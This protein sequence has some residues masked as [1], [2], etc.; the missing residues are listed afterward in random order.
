MVTNKKYYLKVSK[1]LLTFALTLLTLYILFKL[2]IFYTPFLIAFIIG[3]IIEPLIRKVMKITNLTRKTSAIVTVI[4]T[5][6]L[7]IFLLI[8][9]IIGV[10]TEAE[11]IL[12]GL[13]DDIRYIN[14][15][16][17][18]NLNNIKLDKFRIPENIK[19]IIN[20][21]FTDFVGEGSSILQQF[22]IRI[23]DGIRNIPRV[24]ICVGITIIATYFICTDRMYI[25]DQ[26]EHHL[27]RSWVNKFGSK[28]RAVISSLGDY[29]KAQS[30]LILISF[31]IVL[32]GLLIF[33]F[34]G[35]NIEYPILM[36]VFIGLVDALP[37]VG[38]GI[39][40]MPWAIICAFHGDIK[41][42][43]ALVILYVIIVVI[44]QLI[45]PKII[46]NH[47]GIHPI[48]TLIAMYTGFKIIGTIGIFIGPV[49]LIILKSVFE[50]MINNGVVKTILDKN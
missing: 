39:I 40:M 48:F 24:L 44:R 23:L 26:L 38:S 33:K 3:L 18:N 15:F 6:S 36:A 13:N 17:T 49:I 10:I 31:I 16:V 29:L 34:I 1:R 35:M 9:G 41:L 45:E 32:I 46:S 12:N 14:E 8:W 22:L 7:I 28:M 50:T 20:N 2:S 42:A 25:L 43:I 21:T 19:E 11:N 37:L 27:P 4:L 5:F 47:I 30:I